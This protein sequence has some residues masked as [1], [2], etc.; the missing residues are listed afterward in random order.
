M[1]LQPVQGL[2]GLRPLVPDQ[3][4]KL[5][6]QRLGKGLHLQK[7]AALVH[8]R[9]V[10]QCLKVGG[11]VATDVT[12]VQPLLGQKSA[13]GIEHRL[14]RTLK[15]LEN[16]INEVIFRIKKLLGL[17][18]ELRREDPV[19]G[20]GRCSSEERPCGF[21]RSNERIRILPRK[22][23]KFLHEIGHAL[24]DEHG[25]ALGIRCGN[26]LA[27]EVLR[28]ALDRAYLR[29]R[30][31]ALQLNDQTVVAARI[32]ERRPD[33]PLVDLVPARNERDLSRGPEPRHETLDGRQPPAVGNALELVCEHPQGR[34]LPQRLILTQNRQH[35][36][37]GLRFRLAERQLR[38]V[39][40]KLRDVPLS[41][42]GHPLDHLAER[43]DPR[44]K[45]V[46]AFGQAATPVGGR[47][48][49][50]LAR[51][52]HRRLSELV[53]QCLLDPNAKKSVR[54]DTALQQ[55]SSRSLLGNRR[56]LLQ[57]VI[58]PS[59]ENDILQKLRRLR[60]HDCQFGLAQLLRL[61]RKQLRSIRMVRR[62]DVHDQFRVHPPDRVVVDFGNERIVRVI[63]AG[64]LALRQD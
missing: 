35:L 20:F 18:L 15:N 6:A 13:G 37:F 44:R 4:F 8:R 56:V 49:D 43:I 46:K 50:L 60:Q 7:S 12:K 61:E 3:N 45:A 47:D 29:L 58:R 19:I 5:S 31:H 59:V 55:G 32:R 63:R 38:I 25:D 42:G 22:R 39:V 34:A 64:D 26:R 9:R 21:K 54:L 17:G 14:L 2:A 1:L 10:D 48:L 40:E 62:D 24:L 36:L 53:A 23:F 27:E 30:D 28:E 57:K 33:V 41:A 52:K 51:D 16:R 11:L